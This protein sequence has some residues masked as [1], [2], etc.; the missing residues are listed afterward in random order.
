[1]SRALLAGAAL[2]LPLA[3]TWAGTAPA[4]L[5]PKQTATVCVDVNGALKA[6]DCRSPEA[7]RLKPNYD[8][9]TC[10][11]GVRAEASICADGV[12]PPGESAAVQDFR[13]MYLRNRQTLVGA[14][15]QGQWL[16]VPP[17]TA[18]F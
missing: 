7:S 16:C 13:R 6:P 1:M 10:S 12:S 2:A 15:Y 11:K 9:C 3:L 4:Q 5:L 18:N 14:S 8:V 17:R